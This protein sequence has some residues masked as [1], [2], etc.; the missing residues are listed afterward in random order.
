MIVYADQ[1]KTLPCELTLDIPILSLTVVLCSATDD[2]N[3]TAKFGIGTD[4]WV[5]ANGRANHAR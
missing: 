2:K 4:A 3:V 1:D 5:A